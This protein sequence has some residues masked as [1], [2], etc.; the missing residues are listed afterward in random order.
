MES[1][2]PSDYL[3]KNAS[4]YVTIGDYSDVEV[5]KYTYEITD[6]MVQEEIQEELESYSEEESTNAPS[7]GWQCVYRFNYCS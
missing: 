1:I 7:Q 5:T 3:V 2:T 4:D 6:D